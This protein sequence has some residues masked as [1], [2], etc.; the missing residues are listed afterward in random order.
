MSKKYKIEITKTY[1][2]DLLADNE[3]TATDQALEKL[4]EYMLAG[5][6]HYYQTGDTVIETYDVTNTDD[7]FNP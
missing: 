7:P 6:E 5:E 4:D 2:I 3:K 1:C